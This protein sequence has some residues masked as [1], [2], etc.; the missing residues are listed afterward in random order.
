MQLVL[1]LEGEGYMSMGFPELS[2]YQ[3]CFQPP[4]SRYMASVTPIFCQ[5]RNELSE[6]FRNAPTSL[7]QNFL[8]TLLIFIT[9]MNK[10]MKFQRK[11][12]YQNFRFL[13]YLYLQRIYQGVNNLRNL[14]TFPRRNRLKPKDEYEFF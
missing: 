13:Q 12:F 14:V 10:I 7:A 3:E 6:I 5:K 9:I 11:R 4:M 1:Y 8:G 2:L